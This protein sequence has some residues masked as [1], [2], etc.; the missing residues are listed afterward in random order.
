M[1]HM[2]RYH[3]LPY[4]APL[5][6]HRR[7]SSP[8]WSGSS[9]TGRCPAAACHNS[10]AVP[11]TG[12]SQKRTSH[13]TGFCGYHATQTHKTQKNSVSKNKNHSRTTSRHNCHRRKQGGSE[14]PC[15]A[16]ISPIPETPTETCTLS[17]L[18]M[19]IK[20]YFND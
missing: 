12:L 2:T 14:R 9:G 11:S 13:L 7:T 5:T 3:P 8:G 17:L 19:S 18:K 4:W 15:P 16:S 1:L 10:S 20:T 6:G